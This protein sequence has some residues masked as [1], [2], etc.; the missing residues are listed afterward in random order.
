[1]AVQP[2]FVID[3]GES[4]EEVEH[5]VTV[6]PAAEWPTYSN[7]NERGAKRHVNEHDAKRR[8]PHPSSSQMARGSRRAASRASRPRHLARPSLSRS[9]SKQASASPLLS[10]SRGRKVKGECLATTKKKRKEPGCERT[11]TQ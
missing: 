2:V 6:I 4:I 11:V 10:S 1:V 9:T 3:D 7:I 5:S 8:G